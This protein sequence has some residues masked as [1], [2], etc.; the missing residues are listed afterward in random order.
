MARTVAVRGAQG[1]SAHGAIYLLAA[2]LAS[3]ALGMVLTFAP[4][5]LYS[6]Y[7]HPVDT[8]GALSLIRNGWD[9]SALDDQRMG[10][11]IMWSAREPGVPLWG[12][13]DVCPLVCRF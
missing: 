5:V 3:T 4:D 8:L 2:T 1:W 10:G 13:G 6:P 9:L 11:L 12:A 7:E